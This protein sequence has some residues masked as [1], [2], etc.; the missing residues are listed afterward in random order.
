MKPTIALFVAVADNNVIGGNNTLPW[1]L[2][3]DL[4]RFKDIT[5]GNPI[6][7]G[8][9]TYESIGRPLPGR[10]NIVVSRNN[11]FDAPGC[12][13]AST[14]EIAISLAANS[15]AESI[16]IIGGGTIYQQALPYAQKIYLTQVH[17][18]PKGTI[19]FTYPSEEWQEVSRE[20]HSAD[21]K[22]QYD[23]SFITLERKSTKQTLH[24]A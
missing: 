12:T 10:M 17:A 1:R 9:K 4:R 5:M 19:T 11:N 21:E 15:G 13:I 7:M 6:I 20:P 24:P 3:A 8:R 14:L 18:T 16:F 23:Y 2:S 22:N